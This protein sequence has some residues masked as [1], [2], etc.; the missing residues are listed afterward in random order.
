MEDGSTFEEELE[1]DMLTL[2]WILFI[3]LIVGAVAKLVMPGHQPGGIFAT[4]L[5][6]VAGSL[7]A[8]FFGRLLGLYAHGQ[9]AGFIMST[10]GAILLLALYQRITQRRSSVMEPPRGRM[11]PPRGRRAA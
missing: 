5:L 7:V 3:G 2:I 11:E 9:R 6:G 8:G 10:L 4:M 1:I